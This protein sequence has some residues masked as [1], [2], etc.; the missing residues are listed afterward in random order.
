MAFYDS[1]K[2]QKIIDPRAFW[3]ILKSTSKHL[4]K[5]VV[6]EDFWGQFHKTALKSIKKAMGFLLKVESVLRLCKCQKRI[7]PRAFWSNQKS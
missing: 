4:M 5:P 6:Y 3:S 2:C 7:G 1:A